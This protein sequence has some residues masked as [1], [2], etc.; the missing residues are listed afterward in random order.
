MLSIPYSQG[1][2]VLYSIASFSQ[3]LLETVARCYPLQ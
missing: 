3:I 1:E 2:L